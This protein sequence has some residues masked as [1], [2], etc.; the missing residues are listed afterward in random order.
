MYMNRTLIIFTFIQMF[1]GSIEI[2][3]GDDR[4]EK[5]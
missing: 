4:D 3:N 1:F 2:D 5:N